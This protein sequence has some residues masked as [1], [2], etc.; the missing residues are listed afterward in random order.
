[1]QEY[2]TACCS[3]LLSYEIVILNYYVLTKK[4]SRTFYDIIVGNKEP[5]S[6]SQKLVNIL[7]NTTQEEW[8]SYNDIIKNIKEV[9]VQEFQFKVNMSFNL[10]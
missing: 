4:V 6:P 8:N 9:K 3:K 1:M 2:K 10:K 5:T 7:G